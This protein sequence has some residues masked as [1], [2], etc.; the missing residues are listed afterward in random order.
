MNKDISHKEAAQQV[1]E[2]SA[3]YL[4]YWQTAWDKEDA[5][6]Y[7]EDLRLS[8]QDAADI[9]CIGHLLEQ[10][11]VK[12]ARVLANSLD[13]AVREEIP[14]AAWEFLHKD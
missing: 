2:A 7:R 5:K 4:K 11:R 1:K 8:Y 6:R 13:T 14:N 12:E 9:F 3:A 10:N